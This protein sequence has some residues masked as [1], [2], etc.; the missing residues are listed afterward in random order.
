[1]WSLVMPTCPPL[2]SSLTLLTKKED[3][4]LIILNVNNLV[5]P[6]YTTQLRKEII[7]TTNQDF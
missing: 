1:M 2:P 4:R 5:I 6:R 3:N 7:I